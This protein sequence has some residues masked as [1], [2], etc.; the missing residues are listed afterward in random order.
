[1]A[2]LL[3]SGAMVAFDVVVAAFER[4][5]AAW[6]CDLV[7]SALEVLGGTRTER[8][9]AEVPIFK[10]PTPLPLVHLA[11]ANPPDVQDL[12]RDPGAFRLS[13][14]AEDLDR[15]RTQE[16]ELDHCHVHKQALAERPPATPQLQLVRRRII[17]SV[18]P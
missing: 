13:T 12:R 14:P 11:F 10:S 8:G 6:A 15:A 1:M 5:N 18:I 4:A 17:R 16:C 9:Q 3:R 2:D 7:S